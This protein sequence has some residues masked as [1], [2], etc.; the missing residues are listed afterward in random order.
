MT[1]PTQTSQALARIAEGLRASTLESSTLDFKTVGRSREDTLV[2]LAEAAACFANAG[3]G[4]IVV[5]VPDGATSLDSLQ[6]VDLDTRHVQRRIYE[7]TDPALIV[8]VSEDRVNGRRLLAIV[9]P[10]SP[11]VHQVRG[12]ATERLGSDCQP[13]SAQRIASV[14][15]ER[16][17]DD[18]SAEASSSTP[19]ETAPAA[20]DAVR[21][22]LRRVPD[23]E[24][25]SWAELP[26]T[27]LLSRL[28]LIGGAGHLTNGGA[29]L[30]VDAAAPRIDYVHRRTRSGELTTNENLAGPTLTALTRAIELI[31]LRTEGTP[32]N[33]PGGQQLL[34]QDLPEPAVREA[35]VNAVMHRDYR[36][37]GTIQVEHAPTRLS[38][39]SPGGFVTGVTAQNVLTVPSRSRNP[40]LSSALRKLGLAET[41]GIGVDRMYAEMARIGHEPPTFEGTPQS[42]VVTLRGGAPNAPLAKFVATIPE[43]RRSDPDVLLVLLR[44]LVHRTVTARDMAPVLQKGVE[45]V[46]DLLAVLSLPPLE[47]LERTRETTR[48]RAGSYRLRGPVVA[49]LGTAV[50]YRLYAGPESDR[51]IVELVRETGHVNSRMLKTL[52][53]VDTPTASRILAD[54][55]ERGLLAKTSAA[56]RGPSVTYGPGAEFPSRRSPKTKREPSTG[57]GQV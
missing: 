53:D 20:L 57:R 41:A 39:T 2:D 30:L 16:R 51:K 22:L 25:R 37:P 52:L 5:G 54:L 3:G 32:V 1:L 42:V 45:E 4:E 10:P 17:G 8:T 18:W 14:V 35:L 56:A 11:D 19:G 48:N 24:R 26:P 36:L 27:D 12:R 44:L 28:G 34:L 47:L 29:L 40:A 43:D 9:V 46:E 23:N 15:S 49:A 38:V 21:Q 50:R 55:V 7:L 31:E 33:L 13:M 6:E